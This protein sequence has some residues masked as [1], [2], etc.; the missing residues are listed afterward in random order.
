[1]ISTRS[2]TGTTWVQM[3]CA[4]L[5]FQKPSLD[6]PVGWYSPWLDRLTHPKEE[7][8]ARLAAQQHRRFI[9]THS[10]LDGVPIDPRATYIVVGRHPLDS[11]VSL[12]YQG[13]NI[14]RARQ[15]ELTEEVT[16]QPMPAH[17]DR[18]RKPVREW[19]LDWID[20]QASPQ[21]E[22]DSIRGVFW[23]DGDA[24]A[25]RSAPNVVLLHYAE[26]SADLDGQ[27][28]QLAT[29]LGIS[30]P[31]RTWPDL[32]EG[33]TFASMREQAETITGGGQ[34]LNSAAAFFRRGTSGAGRELL[35]EDELAH[36]YARAAE[37][38][39]ADML[40]WL[41]RPVTALA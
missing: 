27:M 35:T 13:Q 41:H 10:P 33:A 8:F 1:V 6:A 16:G 11:A 19:L 4:L 9:K 26:L 38:A 18:P 17:A 31:D 21:Q 20:N 3:I 23:H 5:I 29:R 32:V 40:E 15:R 39:P 34:I 25:R 30:V 7:I 2:K 37:L 12:Y 36:Y 24:W 14:N 28:R 22:M